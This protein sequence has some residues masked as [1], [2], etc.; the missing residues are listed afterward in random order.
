M[1]YFDRYLHIKR[2]VNNNPVVRDP[3]YTIWN[4]IKTKTFDVS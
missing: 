4:L 3:M 2:F 1:Y